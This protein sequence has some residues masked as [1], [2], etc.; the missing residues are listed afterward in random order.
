MKR[1]KEQRKKILSQKKEK[2]WKKKKEKERRRASS[3]WKK[4]LAL[5]IF[6]VCTL[7]SNNSYIQ[8]GFQKQ[9]R[10]SKT[11]FLYLYKNKF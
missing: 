11:T 7:N 2:N 8:N 3:S 4:Y 10:F 6:A 9:F 1:E 5:F